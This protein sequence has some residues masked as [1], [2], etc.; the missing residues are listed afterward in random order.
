M[1]IADTN[2]PYSGYCKRKSKNEGLRRVSLHVY[3][4]YLYI[5][6]TCRYTQLKDG[7]EYQFI[8]CTCRYTQLKNGGEYQYIACTCRYTQLKDGGEYQCQVNTEPKISV[9]IFLSVEGIIVYRIQRLLFLM[10]D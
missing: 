6:C 10:S 4:L 8:I 2:K 9:S 7:G 1:W 5:T 3:L